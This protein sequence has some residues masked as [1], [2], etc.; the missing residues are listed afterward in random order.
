M[1]RTGSGGTTRFAVISKK[2]QQGLLYKPAQLQFDETLN[3]HRAVAHK[4]I[5]KWASHRPSCAA[6][7][8]SVHFGVYNFGGKASSGSLRAHTDHIGSIYM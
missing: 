1:K 6:I 2:S 7:Y 3:G 4:W 8:I 5:G